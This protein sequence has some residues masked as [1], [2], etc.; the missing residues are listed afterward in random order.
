M[1]IPLE[2]PVC[3]NKVCNKIFFLFQSH[4]EASEPFHFVINVSNRADLLLF[5]YLSIFSM[6]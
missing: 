1:D 3:L 6:T 5:I 2:W 4:N